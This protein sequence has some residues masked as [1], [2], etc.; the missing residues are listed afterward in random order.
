MSCELWIVPLVDALCEHPDNPFAE[1]L[2]RYQRALTGAE[3]GE[4]PIYRYNPDRSPQVRQVADFDYEALH[5]LRR[6][7]LLQLTG[8]EITPTE[9]LDTEYAEL[10]HT[11]DDTAA[12]SPLVWHY[13]H[14][15]A[16]VPV[17]FAYPVNNE[18]LAAQDGPLGSSQSLL[19]ELAELAPLL[20]IDPALEDPAAAVP[21]A[22]LVEGDSAA[23]LPA[24][25]GQDGPF[26]RECL[27]WLGL[28]RAAW[29][30]V[31]DGALVVLG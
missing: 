24:A 10:L 15:G 27:A 7:R 23:P 3:L 5:L 29:H 6:V 21:A 4:V 14:A 18:E 22:G 25:Q 13:D 31:G 26:A 11:Y 20:G 16:Y 28:Y 2:D 17:D 12:L 8:F 30:S 19:R 1:D 9:T